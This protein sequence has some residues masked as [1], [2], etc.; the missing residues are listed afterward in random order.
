MEAIELFCSTY[1]CRHCC[2]ELMEC[3][4]CAQWWVLIALGVAFGHIT[5]PMEGG[6]E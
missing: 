6:E 3:R 1:Y 2:G 4:W 5:L